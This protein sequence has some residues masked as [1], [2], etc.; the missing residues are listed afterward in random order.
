MLP[1]LIAIIITLVTAG[2]FLLL[3]IWYV[4]G[5]SI[6][7]ED[8]IVSRNTAGTGLVMQRYWIDWLGY[9]VD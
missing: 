3:G 7:V 6:S 2:V 5:R 1:T 9:M 4:R 8:Y